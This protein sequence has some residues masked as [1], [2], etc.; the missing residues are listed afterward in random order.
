VL[1]NEHYQSSVL[2]STAIAACSWLR[3]LSCACSCLRARGCVL[4]GLAAFWLSS[5]V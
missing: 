2:Y 4:Y 1:T 5:N 3:T